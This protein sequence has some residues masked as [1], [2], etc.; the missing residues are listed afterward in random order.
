MEKACREAQKAASTPEAGTQNE[1]DDEKVEDD[2]E[3]DEEVDMLKV[4]TH[5]GGLPPESGAC[6]MS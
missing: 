6:L 3:T 2:S 4:A 5:E 1:E